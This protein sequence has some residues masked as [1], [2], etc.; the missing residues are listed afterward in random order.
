VIFNL[1]IKNMAELTIALVATGQ[2]E[3]SFEG[4]GIKAAGRGHSRKWSTGKELLEQLEAALRNSRDCIKNLY[5]FS[6][7]WAYNP[8]GNR[9][10]VYSGGPDGSGFYLDRR[11][12]GDH[13]DAR[14]LSDL[15]NLIQR[16][17]IRFCK[18]AEIFFTG[19]RVAAS[20]FP[21]EIARITKSTVRAAK[22][23]CFPK[24]GEAGSGQRPGDETGEWVSGAGSWDEKQ[25]GGCLGWKIFSPIIDGGV[26]SGEDSNGKETPKGHMIDIW[27]P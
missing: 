19:C 22:G 26:A 23:A 12:R 27:G 7:A 24:P 1:K 9:G 4:W 3:K 10:G 16:G 14:Y 18:N 11:R 5:I 15:S 17:R 6:H 2:D 13:P 8:K 25:N 20:D 21:A